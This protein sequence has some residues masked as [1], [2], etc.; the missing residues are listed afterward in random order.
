MNVITSVE[1]R[2][3]LWKPVLI[4]GLCGGGI[5]IV[6]VMLYGILTGLNSVEVA[7]QVTA[8]VFRGS[9]EAPSAPVVG[10]AI[11]MT[12]SLVVTLAYASLIWRP[13]LQ[14]RGPVAAVSVA[15]LALTFIWA[16]NFLL[17]LPILN[18][19]F[20][21]LLPYAVTLGSKILFGMAMA[22][23]FYT[24]QSADFKSTGQIAVRA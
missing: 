14:Q 23:V 4:A 9:A 7:G 6:W 1:T 3:N 5:E 22:G 13:F 24:A 2:R 18:P 16:I 17:I 21:D 19:V 10:L 12:L 8:S 11:H 15:A 20:I